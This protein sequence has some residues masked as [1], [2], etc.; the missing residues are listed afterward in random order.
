M[1]F[2]QFHSVSD[3]NSK[4]NKIAHTVH[5]HFNKHESVLIYVPSDEAAA[6]INQLLWKFPHDSFLPHVIAKGPVDEK[7]AIT[8][9]AANINKASVLINLVSSIPE[10]ASEFSIIHELM[11]LT[12]PAK[13]E[14][15]K[16]RLEEY[17]KKNWDVTIC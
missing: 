4:L 2:V 15:S 10:H 6:F 14:L 12:H 8:T 11:D 7:V 1:P 16:K 9:I 3:N 13:E 17:S 5:N